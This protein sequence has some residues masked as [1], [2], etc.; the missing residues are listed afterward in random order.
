MQRS[1]A[2]RVA[3]KLLD[4][5]QDRSVDECMAVIGYLMTAILSEVPVEDRAEEMAGWVATVSDSFRN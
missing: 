3:V 2:Q 1:E 5:L 4:M